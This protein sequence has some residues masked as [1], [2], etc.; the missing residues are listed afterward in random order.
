MNMVPTVA[1]NVD[2]THHIDK[3][4]IGLQTEQKL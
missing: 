3:N 1:E 2:E 4:H